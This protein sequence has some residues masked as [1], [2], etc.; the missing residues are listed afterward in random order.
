MASLVRTISAGILGS[1]LTLHPTENAFVTGVLGAANAE[2]IADVDGKSGAMLDLR[3]TF[4]MTIEVSGTVDGTNWVLIPARPIG[5]A[6]KQY[7]A[8][9]A[10]SAS[11]IWAVSC[12]GFRKIRARVTAYTSGSAVATISA[13]NA[14]IDQTLEGM[15][16][17]LVVT[18]TGAAAA[19]VTLSLPTPGAGLRQYITYISINRFAAA[20]LTA[21]AAPVLVTTTNIP[22][23]LVFTRPADAMTLGQM[24]VWREDF[25]FPIAAS[26]QNTAVTIVAPATTGVIW[27]LTAGYYVA[28]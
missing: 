2:I 18:N 3:G 4:N 16:S 19:A 27:R 25:A 5:Q 9:I 12:G 14:D 20:A 10:G 28:P 7:V 17:P 8:A 1:P 11:G 15:V 6:A 26:A 24:D 23:T 21:A 22:G 13:S